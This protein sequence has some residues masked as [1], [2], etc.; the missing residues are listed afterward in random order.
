VT[1]SLNEAHLST[2][3]A[4]TASYNISPLMLF[5]QVAVAD[6]ENYT[7]NVF[8]GEHVEIIGDTGRWYVE[9]TLSQ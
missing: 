2:R 1:E 9:L 8:C 7:G 5:G 3:G 4:N 6:C